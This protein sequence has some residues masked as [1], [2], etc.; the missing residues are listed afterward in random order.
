MIL[1]I[2]IIILLGVIT[3][4]IYNTYIKPAAQITTPPVY[5]PVPTFY[6]RNGNTSWVQ[7]I[8]DE[9]N[10][11]E[12]LIEWNGQMS[13]IVNP[14]ENDTDKLAIQFRFFAQYWLDK[15]NINYGTTNV[16]D[17]FGNL[18]KYEFSRSKNIYTAKFNNTSWN[19]DTTNYC[20]NTV[21]SKR[22]NSCLGGWM[23]NKNKCFPPA[24]SSS[25][26]NNYNWDTMY[27]YVQPSEINDW[28][29]KCNVTNDP[30]CKYPQN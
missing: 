17:S 15:L 1:I 11:V 27:N 14:N 19:W 23:Y 28:M 12:N 7:D 25:T 13:N 22:E 21:N 16:Y 4:F 5:N 18:G 6:L 24:T 29:Q 8:I 10:S 2:I 3:W 20:F 9:N 30:D 26:C